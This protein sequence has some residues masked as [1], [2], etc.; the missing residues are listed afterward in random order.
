MIPAFFYSGLLYSNRHLDKTID[1]LLPFASQ[2]PTLMEK[3]TFG[4]ETDDI[5]NT[6]KNL[7]HL[8]IEGFSGLPEFFKNKNDIHQFVSFFERFTLQRKT[9]A[10]ECLIIFCNNF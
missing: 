1:M 8:A 7:M 5:F 9:F 3:A 2:L 10:D 6:S 4:L